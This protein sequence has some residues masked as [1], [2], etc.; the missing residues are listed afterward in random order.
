M[1]GV[2]ERH[3]ILARHASVW[4]RAKRIHASWRDTGL[5]CPF[6]TV[7]FC[8]H[9]TPGSPPQATG[10]WKIALTR[11]PVCRRIGP[12]C[13]ANIPVCGFTELSSSV[14]PYRPRAHAGLPSPR[15]GRLE[16]LRCWS[17]KI[18]S[19]P[20]RCLLEDP[21]HG[22]AWPSNGIRRTRQRPGVLQPS[23][24]LARGGYRSS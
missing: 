7:S 23:G 22:P 9:R 17:N 14:F 1:G 24:A 11:R 3:W 18:A 8:H 13:S 10:D 16:S 12:R 19:S 6:K 15:N 2:A 4:S 20:R 5:P 21:N